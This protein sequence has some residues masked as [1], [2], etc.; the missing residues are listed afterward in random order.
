[1]TDDKEESEKDAKQKKD[2][3][4]ALRAYAAVV[5]ELPYAFMPLKLDKYDLDIILEHSDAFEVYIPQLKKDEFI[6]NLSVA[7]FKT[8]VES[9]ITE[10][11]MSSPEE[12]KERFLEFLKIEIK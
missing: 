10:F 4:A 11:N 6:D 8:S 7:E 5:R 3:E 2:N 12:Q 1:L 9:I